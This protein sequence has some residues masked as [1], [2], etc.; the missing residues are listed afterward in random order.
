MVSR[1]EVRVVVSSCYSMLQCQNKWYT[2]TNKC[3]RAG[4]YSQILPD[5]FLLSFW[6]GHKSHEWGQG[7]GRRTFPFVSWP[8]ST[9]IFTG[10]LESRQIPPPCPTPPHPRHDIH[11]RC[12]TWDEACSDSYTQTR[13]LHAHRHCAARTSFPAPDLVTKVHGVQLGTASHTHYTEWNSLHCTQLSY[14]VVCSILTGCFALW[15]LKLC[16][17]QQLLNIGNFNHNYVW[18]L[19]LFCNC[20]FLNSHYRFAVV[21]T[22]SLLTGLTFFPTRN[23][24]SNTKICVRYVMYGLF[25]LAF[26]SYLFER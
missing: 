24:G 12:C 21:Q 23:K 25:P 1:R 13:I 26:K 4:R 9:S 5:L 20:I 16:I 11:R 7:G 3:T 2:H 8:T 18:M 14:R 15:P 10:S 6:K 22:T 17:M 19:L